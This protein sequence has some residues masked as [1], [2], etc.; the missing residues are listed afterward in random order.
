VK[1]LV[2]G[3]SGFVGSALCAHLIT[4]G[5]IVRGAVRRASD[6]PMPGLD[7]R[8]VSD[9]SANTNWSEALAG[10]NAVVH[11]AARVH[12]MNEVS[13]DPLTAFR[14]ANVKGT[15]CLVQQAVDSAVKRFVYISSVKVNGEF[16]DGNPFRADDTPAPKDPYGISK[17]EAEQALRGIAD[18]TDL[19]V[20]II[21]PPLIY[22]PGVSANFLKLM[23]G[24]MLG[25][26]LPFGAISNSRSMVALENL[27]DLIETCLSHPEA[28]DQTFLVS[29]GE[30][31]S[32]KSLLQ[33]T[34]VALGK[35]ARLIPVPISVLWAISRLF[36]RTDFA[37]RLCGSLQVD[38]SKTRDYLG[39]SP[40]VSVD[41]AL[42]KT[43]KYFLSH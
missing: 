29:D 38:I 41:K 9:L 4:K 7:V 26:P 18:K 17:W 23:Q 34:A 40:P 27:V 20:V 11:C 21:R 43:A 6:K 1:V 19:E 32:I 42:A 25:V 10:I 33:R 16:T 14:K 31:L 3:A 28:V 13:V 12:I 8:V 22:G 5:H 36:G 2:T 39:W 24:I 37:Q 30:D 35:P 15:A